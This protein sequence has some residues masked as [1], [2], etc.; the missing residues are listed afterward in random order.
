M[1]P[2]TTPLQLAVVTGG[3]GFDVPNF[4]RL[5]RRLNGIEAYIQTMGDFASSAQPVRDGY[6]VILFYH[7]LQETPSDA[8][9]P[10]YDSK[11]VQ[12]LERVK[13]VGQGVVALH[14]SLLAYPQWP[15]WRDLTGIDP[16]WRSYHHD[17]PLNLE[18]A[19]HDHPITRG[20]AGFAVTD[21]TY[22]IN[23]PDADNLVLLESQHAHSV[24]AQAWVRQYGRSRV[25][26]LVLG[27]DQTAWSNP[28]FENLLNRGILW[29]AGKEI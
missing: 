7:M 22:E 24:R 28:G 17:Q 9:K 5:F 21:E 16:T 19:A 3:H 10:W 8:G 18:V 15:A 6:D 27:H 26:S 4:H 11:P 20:L 2:I 23:A 13:E 29:S 14:H 25:F 1:T 12:A